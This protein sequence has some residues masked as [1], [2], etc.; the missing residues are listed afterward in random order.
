MLRVW[1]CLGDEWRDENIIIKKYFIVW[2]MNI[3]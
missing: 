1:A 3:S 2:G